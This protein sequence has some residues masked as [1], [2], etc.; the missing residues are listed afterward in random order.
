[1]LTEWFAVLHIL[2]HNFTR[3]CGPNTAT[4]F[5]CVDKSVSRTHTHNIWLHMQM[6]CLTS[7]CFMISHMLANC[8]LPCKPNI[9]S[10][11]NYV[12][13]WISN[14]HTIWVLYYNEQRLCLLEYNLLAYRGK[15]HY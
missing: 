13:K 12:V 5:N 9:L 15:L 14:T 1:M 7:V 3:T 6:Y 2:G 11:F 10:I 8:S 4:I